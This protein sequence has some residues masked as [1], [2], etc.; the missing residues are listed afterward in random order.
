MASVSWDDVSQPILKDLNFTI[1][2]AKLTMIIGLVGSGKTTLLHMLLG[3]TRRNSGCIQVTFQDATHCSQRPRISNTALRQ[4]I[5][6]GYNYDPAWYSEVVSYCCLKKDLE[7]LPEGDL[8]MAGSNGVGLGGDQQVRISLARAIY[9]KKKI[10][11]MDDV[12][13]GPDLPTEEAVFL[14]VFSLLGLLKQLNV[15]VILATNAVHRLPNAD[16]IIVLSQKRTIAEQA[17]FRLIS[18]RSGYASK[19]DLHQR[20][21]GPSGQGVK[22]SYGDE[23][24][25]ALAKAL[26][27]SIPTTSLLVIGAYTSIT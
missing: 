4:K 10:M 2:D 27:K 16:H 3:E 6:R 12:L 11:V 9:S 21:D 23:T 1:T 19:L 26:R 8:T 18:S 25:E 5:M 13:S 14:S 24:Q 15:T 20:Q 7:Q 17:S 22:S